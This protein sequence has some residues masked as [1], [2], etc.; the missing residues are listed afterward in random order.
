MTSEGSA[1]NPLEYWREMFQKSTEAWAQ[2]AGAAGNPF[3]PPGF[4]AMPGGAMPGF[5]TAAGFNATPGANPFGPF[6][7][8]FSP[9]FSPPFS[10]DMQQV[11]QQFFNAWAEQLRQAA[12]AG[13][14][15]PE[16]F[17]DA[18][19]QWTEQLEALAKMFA[20]VMGAEA[21]SRM[22]GKSM[23]QTLVWQQRMANSAEPQL[24]DI[25]KAFNMPS[26]SQID[27][28]FERVIGLEER[29][30]G[31]EDDNRKLRSL[32]EAALGTPPARARAPRNPEVADGG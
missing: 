12:A 5:G 28:M 11:W 25:L 26:R 30:D 18:Q 15:G 27:R 29:I 2:A 17:Q 1:A 19:K 24:E 20:E 7:P 4:G 21:F 9:S 6:M 13:T 10:N 16:A 23:E 31:L 3:Q 22:L 32:L 8:P 14:P